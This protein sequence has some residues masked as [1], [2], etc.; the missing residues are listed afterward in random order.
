MEH[1]LSA[2]QSDL[3]NISGEIQSLQ[4][5]SMSMS[6]K[7]ANRKAVQGPLSS[8]VGSL[9]LSSELIGAILDLEVGEEFEVRPHEDGKWFQRLDA[10]DEP[11]LSRDSWRPATSSCFLNR[12]TH[13]RRRRS[14]SCTPSWSLRQLRLT[15]LRL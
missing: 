10:D 9:A 13:F 7:L 8:F 3:G 1:M 4:E 2:F 5:Q 14:R 6:V 12:L 11:D 15:R